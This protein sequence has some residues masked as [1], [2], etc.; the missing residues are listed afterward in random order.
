MYQYETATEDILKIIGYVE[1]IEP[2]ELRK[3]VEEILSHMAKKYG[4]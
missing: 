3:Y 4:V 2:V 1:I